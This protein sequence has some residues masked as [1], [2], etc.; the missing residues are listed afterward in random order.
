MEL[1]AKNEQETVWM[2]CKNT[3]NQEMDF[4]RILQQ[5]IRAASLMFTQA[6]NKN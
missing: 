5:L 1:S 4:L 2:E 6:V 3:E